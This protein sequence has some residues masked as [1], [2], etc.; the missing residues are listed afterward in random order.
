MPLYEYWC[1]DCRQS[2]E[3][4]RSMTDTASTVDCP[5]CHGGSVQRVFTPIAAFSAS[6]GQR[7]AIG[8]GSGCAGCATT[9]C[10]GCAT[11]RKN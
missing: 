1:P 2:F 4:R 7:T 11:A 3:I 6:G 5:V 10:A 9:S 8:G